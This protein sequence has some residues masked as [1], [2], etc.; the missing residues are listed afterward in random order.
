VNGNVAIVTGSSRLSGRAI[1]KRGAHAEV[2]KVQRLFHP[3]MPVEIKADAI[4]S[5][6]AVS[7][8]C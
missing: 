1:A 6:E 7:P 2:V 4:V 3:D 8:L 5:N